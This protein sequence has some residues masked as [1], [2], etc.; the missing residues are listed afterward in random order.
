MYLKA[1][2][3]VRLKSGGPKMTVNAIVAGDPK[4]AFCAWFDGHML[5]TLRREDFP[6]TSLE[7]I[8]APEGDPRKAT[9]RP[10]ATFPETD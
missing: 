10:I 6:V 7:L 8:E 9:L 4:T 2:S 5:F 1:G 3:I